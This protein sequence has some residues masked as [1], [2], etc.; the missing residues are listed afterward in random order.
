MV[1]ILYWSLAILCS[2]LKGS[3]INDAV[4]A[5][6]DLHITMGVCQVS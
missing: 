6:N 2:S 3:L 1:V 5:A 4:G